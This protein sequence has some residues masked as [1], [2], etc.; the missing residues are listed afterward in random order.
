MH[1]KGFMRGEATPY[2]TLIRTSVYERIRG[3]ILSCALRPG[4]MLQ[5]RELAERYAVS[6][7]PVR[8]A[9]LRLEEQALVEVLPR[10]GYRVKPVS[11]ADAREMYEMRQILERA[12][13]ARLIETASDATMKALER[14]ARGPKDATV[15]EWIEYNRRFHLALAESCGNARLARATAE[16]IAQFDRLTYMSVSSGEAIA[17]SRFATE[18][19]E[20]VAAIRKREKRAAA[21]L[22]KEHI[23]SSRKRLLERLE[24][25]PVV[26]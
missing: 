6:K 11:I 26:P 14:L 8:D 15:A 16:V 13:V 7:S 25:Q 18:H 23:E 17:L 22:V 3:E 10:K 5:E 1:A 24:S 12:C 2:P 20:I 4:A 19:A 21:T 9:L